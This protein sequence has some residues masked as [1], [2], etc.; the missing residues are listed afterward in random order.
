MPDEIRKRILELDGRAIP[1]R[2]L[3]RPGRR[4]VAI[5]LEPRL[6]LS[7]LA[8][9]RLPLREIDAILSREQ[10][11]L[12]RKLQDWAH[13]ER[14]HPPRRFVD[15]ES[16]LLLGESWLLTVR[17]AGDGRRASVRR[18]ERRNGPGRIELRLPGPLPEAARRAL[19]ESALASW[20][21]RLAR[22]ILAARVAYWS[23][24]LGLTAGPISIRDNRSRWGSCSASGRLSFNWKIVMAAPAVIDYLVVHEICHLAHP[25]HS[26]EFWGRV[27]GA[28]PDYRPPRNWLRRHGES[29]YL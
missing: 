2:L 28:L 6:G 3:R 8:P 4:S 26:P 7:V 20:Y 11:W 16:L 25:D 10:A 18:E 17:E 5:E 12:R 27:E 9:A 21:R 13:W 1:Y 15:G 24:I 14:S 19:A 23:A 22:R 29:L